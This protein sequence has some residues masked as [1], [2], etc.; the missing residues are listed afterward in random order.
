MLTPIHMLPNAIEVIIV[1]QMDLNKQAH[2]LSAAQGVSRQD[3]LLL[4]YSYK[5]CTIR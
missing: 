3:S 1:H 4:L 2:E 5:C